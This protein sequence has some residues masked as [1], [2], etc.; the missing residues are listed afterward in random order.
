MPT[1]IENNLTD[2]NREI[3][4]YTNLLSSNC[5]QCYGVI[6]NQEINLDDYIHDIKEI[7]NT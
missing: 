6:H 2:I 4:W 1:I 7:L 3:K 5:I